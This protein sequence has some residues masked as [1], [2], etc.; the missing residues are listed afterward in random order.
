MKKK[1]ISRCVNSISGLYLHPLRYV[2]NVVC[3]FFFFCVICVSNRLEGHILGMMYMEIK[4]VRLLRRKLYAWY[5]AYRK[6][7]E[8]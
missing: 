8:Y 2:I 7:G 4:I 6:N 5:N 3:F 1:K